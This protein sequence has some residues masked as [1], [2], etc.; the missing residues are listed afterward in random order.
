MVAFRHLGMGLLWISGVLF[1]VG[2]CTSSTEPTTPSQPPLIGVVT[3]RYDISDLMF[4]PSDSTGRVPD[5]IEPTTTV[6][7]SLFANAAR[8]TPGPSNAERID[9]IRKYITEN[10]DPGTWRAN[11][12]K[13]EPI[14][15][16]TQ[17]PR[18]EA[19]LITQTPAAQQKVAALLEDLRRSQSVQISIEVRVV[20]LEDSAEKQLP[21]DLQN[22][23]ALVRNAG[24]YRR[25][26]HLTSEQRIALFRAI[27]NTDRPGPR[28]TLFSGQHAAMVIQT[29]QAYVG[30]LTE[31]CTLGEG[32]RPQWHFEPV[33]E[34][35]TATGVIFQ[36]SA[37]P[38][39][40]SK[41]VFVDFRAS[42][43]KLLE[44]LPEQF[45]GTHSQTPGTIQRPVLCTYQ[46]SGAVAMPDDSSLLLGTKPEINSGDMAF[47]ANSPSRPAT[48]A[49]IKRL[50]ETASHGH[51]YLLLRPKIHVQKTQPA[52][53][54]EAPK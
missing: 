26:V 44:V 15:V 53:T 1:A 46:M 43:A 54:Q 25:D 52:T 17:H 8:Y 18:Q 27:Q 41:T 36:V 50:A 3:Q 31:V 21:A 29:Q 34:T 11:G 48:D 23:L 47:N 28:V 37:C 40:D 32:N 51:L 24:R 35:I 45:I 19:L 39:P 10:V 2:G 6:S 12:G 22:Q 13:I 7:Q 30:N 4:V 5:L 38:S 42:V 14:A 49:A 20:F 33:V 16:N 9:D